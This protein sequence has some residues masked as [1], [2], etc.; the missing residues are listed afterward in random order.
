MGGNSHL[1]L[2]LVLS[3]YKSNTL[4]LHKMG[5]YL[6]AESQQI[7]LLPSIAGVII[8]L[9]NVTYSVQEGVGSVS[10]CARLIGEEME[11]SVT[12]ETQDVLSLGRWD[13]M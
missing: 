5:C 4:S 7:K 2:T 1:T 12:V 3:G 13:Y 10:I 11:A 8:G 6:V 9:E